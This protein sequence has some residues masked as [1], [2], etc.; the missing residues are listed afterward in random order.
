[1]VLTTH[2]GGAV[3][4]AATEVYLAAAALMLIEAGGSLNRR[5]IPRM[6]IGGVFE[7]HPN[8]KLVMTEQPGI[9]VTNLLTEMDSAVFSV[10]HRTGAPLPRAPSEYFLS[11]VFVG[12]SFMSPAEAQAAHR[13]G[14]WTNM[15]WG[16]DYPHPEGTWKYSDDR[17]AEPMTRLS[18]RHAFSG[19]P[20]A[21][22]RAMAG[23]NAVSVY[24]LDRASVSTTAAR[25]G[26]TLAQVT[27]PLPCVPAPDGPER[28]GM[29]LCAFRTVGAWA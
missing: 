7:R 18:L 3:D 17:G 27:S 9:W 5:A 25:I 23:E 28:E 19:I 6:I 16:R 26:P 2:A 15:L 12:A 14:Y 8:L 21:Q 1:M 22:V 4:P 20:E 13:E 10:P 11:N 29:G 24:N